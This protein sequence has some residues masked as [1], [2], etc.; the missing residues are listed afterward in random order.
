MHVDLTKDHY[1][2]VTKKW[3]EFRE[4]IRAHTCGIQETNTHHANLIIS[5]YLLIVYFTFI[6]S[7]MFRLF[8]FHLL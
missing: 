1:V 4:D 8:T 7:I 3:Q 5:C 2:H 6:F